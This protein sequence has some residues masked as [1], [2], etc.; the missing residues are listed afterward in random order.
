[1]FK[2]CLVTGGAGFIGSNLTIALLEQG[3]EVRVLDNFS[4]G[5]GENL[6]GY[7]REIEIID[8]DIRNIHDIKEAI[9]SAEV[10][11]HQ[12]ALPSVQLSVSDPLTANE[13]NITGTLNIFVAAKEC[14]VRRV[15]Y[16]SSCA[17]YGNN[18]SLPL[19]EDMLPDPASP[20]AAGKLA[21]EA[22]GK[23]FNDLYG[24]ETVGLRYFNVFGP[25]QD[26]NSQYSAVIPRFV[27]DLLSGEGP[28]V[29]GDGEQSRDFVFVSD[30][31]KANLLAATIPSAAGEVFNIAAGRQVTLNSLLALLQKITNKSTHVHYTAA[32]KGD[33]RHSLADIGKARRILG[34]AP[35]LPLESALSRTARWFSA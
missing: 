26:P 15:V 31:V 4:T 18:E 3:V 21:G 24:L 1:M 27:K 22:Y 9:G 5:R 6:S 29:Y 10:V 11:F 19:A 33:I 16:A 23:V 35:E 28:T 30:I 14:G 20:Y 25:R 32:R 13:V 34:Y 2:T 17:V 7:E 8:G 12:A